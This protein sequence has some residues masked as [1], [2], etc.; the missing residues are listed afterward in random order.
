[1]E[2]KTKIHFAPHYLQNPTHKISIA[3]IGCGGTGSQVITCLARINA[4]LLG[5]SHPGLHVE[6]Y[7]NDTVSQA[8]M[9]RQL[10]S[11]SDLGRSKA[12]VHIERINRFFG[13]NWISRNELYNERSKATY[14]FLIS[15]VDRIGTRLLIDEKFNK[16]ATGLVKRNT[17][18]FD[19]PYYWMDFGNAMD[20]GQ[21]VLGSKII[22]QPHTE[23]FEQVNLLPSL[24]RLYPQMKK[25]KDIDS[26]PS[27]SIAEAIKKQDL[28]VNS[29]LAQLGCNIIWKLIKEGSIQ[30]QGAFLNLNNLSVKS[31]KL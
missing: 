1:M 2:K 17:D 6:V 26:G 28:F 27:C 11:P 19:R 20:Y 29:I 25:Q 14:N 12:D 16:S 13:L 3:L 4:T 10:F 9:G 24:F 7:D 15:C 18:D 23:E 22:K 31:I 21:I 5:L 8:N 30:H